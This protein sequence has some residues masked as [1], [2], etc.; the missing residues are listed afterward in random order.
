MSAN[1]LS[2]GAI[3]FGIII[4]GAVVMVEGIFVVL[5]HRAKE[6]GMATFNK[7]SKLGLIKRS[8]PLLT[9]R[10]YFLPN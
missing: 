4:D 9:A 1:L 3:D 7:I 6:V 8:L 2:M 5:D 10:A